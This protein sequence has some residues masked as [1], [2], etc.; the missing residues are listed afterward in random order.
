MSLLLEA[1]ENLP[2]RLNTDDPDLFRAGAAEAIEQ[3]Y[4]VVRERYTEGTLGR[5]LV[6]HLDVRHRRAAAVALGLVGTMA[7]NPSVA[8]AL[9]D[10]DEQVRSTAIDAIWDIWFRGDGGS[11]GLEL[12]RL[13][14][15]TDDAERITYLDGL[16]SKYPDYAEAY[17]QLAIAW[18]NRGQY[19]RAAAECET[20]LRLNPYHFGAAAG[21][22]QCYLK[23]N[24]PGAAVRAF[25]QA[26]DL[27]PD[28]DNLRDVM[29]TLRKRTAE[30]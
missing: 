8:A 30:E 17:N 20:V 23:M 10:D 12:R 7:S 11:Q 2:V 22:G 14:A 1:F 21:Q 9:K 24:K 27:N 5:I 18:F 3:F 15:M 13:L 6:S 4:E 25:T 16:I 19:A 29:E 26:L 28:L